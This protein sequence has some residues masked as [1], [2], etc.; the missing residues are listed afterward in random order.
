MRTDLYVVQAG[1]RGPVKIGSAADVNKRLLQLQGANHERLTLIARYPQCGGFEK[2]LH[3]VLS[4]FRIGGEWFSC[5]PELI[6][7]CAD[8]LRDDTEFLKLIYRFGRIPG[9]KRRA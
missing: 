8:R 2:L 1:K 5:C 4:P 6:R 7:R 9:E 3:A